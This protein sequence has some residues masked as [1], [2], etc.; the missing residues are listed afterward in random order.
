MWGQDGT[1][2]GRVRDGGTA[3]ES[4]VIRDRGSLSIIGLHTGRSADHRDVVELIEATA[5]TRDSYPLVY[6]RDNGSIYHHPDV[7]A[8]LAEHQVIV[9]RSLPRTP[10]HNGATECSIGELKATAQLGKGCR[11]DMAAAETRMEAAAARLNNNRMR[12]SK[13]F[14][15]SRELDEKL[16]R[17]EASRRALFYQLC[18]SRMQAAL[19]GQKSVR[20]GRMAEREAIFRTLEE[21][22]F[23]KR[24]QGGNRYVS[25]SEIIL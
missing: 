7:L 13:E 17:P 3:I 8:H 25:K 9:L 15:T 5:L 19:V 6:G 21:F 23:I 11:L 22:G 24:T 16:A 2:L 14:K 20:A 18:R 1:H 10:Q 4:Q 12:A